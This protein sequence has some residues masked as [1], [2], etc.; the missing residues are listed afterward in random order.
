MTKPKYTV[1]WVASCVYKKNM[2]V[3]P[4]THEYYQYL[5]VKSGSGSI[6]ANGEKSPLNVGYIHILPPGVQHSIESSN[7]GM[8]TYELKFYAN[9]ENDENVP[10]EPMMLDISDT[11]AE[12]VFKG[13]FNEMTNMHSFYEEMLSVKIEELH[14]WLKR[15]QNSSEK[16]E[17][18][19]SYSPKFTEVIFY[20]EQRYYD[21]I[22]LKTLSDIAHMEKIYFLKKFKA[23]VGTTPVNYLRKLRINKSKKLLL[24]SEFNI[25]QIAAAVGFQ[26]IHHF[27]NVFKD[28]VGMS[29]S[30]YKELHENDE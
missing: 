17:K 4:H 9:D 27:S 16:E 11:R 13:M 14:L 25:T 6:E 30:E 19:S 2:L 22:S 21:D 10:K 8:T 26:S 5:Y 23:E 24:N 3:V 29:P 1:R 18:R 15:T 28:I 20:M 7:E 12:S